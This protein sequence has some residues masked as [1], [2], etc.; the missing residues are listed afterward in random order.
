MRKGEE[1]KYD[2]PGKS[3][4]PKKIRKKNLIS[5]KLLHTSR[6]LRAIYFADP[7]AIAQAALIW[8]WTRSQTSHRFNL[9]LYDKP[10]SR[11]RKLRPGRDQGGERLGKGRR[12]RRLEASRSPL[13]S[14]VGTTGGSPPKY[15]PR[16]CTRLCFE[17]TS[18]GGSSA[19]FG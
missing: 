7:G 11:R 4:K 17:N 6:V 15:R 16:A 2:H 13:T 10:F 14:P 8:L 12:R 18:H 19:E 1:E 5:K 9:G 3:Q